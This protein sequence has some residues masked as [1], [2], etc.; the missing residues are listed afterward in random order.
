M[1][2]YRFVPADGSP[3]ID[4]DGDVWAWLRRLNAERANRLIV[5]G[6]SVNDGVTE[7]GKIYADDY[8]TPDEMSAAIERGQNR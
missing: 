3:A 7:L 8:V 6:T 1:T 4:I 2:T 5:H